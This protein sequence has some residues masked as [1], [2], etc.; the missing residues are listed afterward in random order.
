MYCE[1]EVGVDAKGVIQ[2]LKITWYMNGGAFMDGSYGTPS[3]HC[4]LSL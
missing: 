2:G 4:E 3:S 1:Y